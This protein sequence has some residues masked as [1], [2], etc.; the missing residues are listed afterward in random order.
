MSKVFVVIVIVV[1]IDGHFWFAGSKKNRGEVHNIDS[2]AFAAEKVHAVTAFAG[3]MSRKHGAT[4]LQPLCLSFATLRSVFRGHGR[5]WRLTSERTFETFTRQPC[6]FFCSRL[7]RHLAD[8]LSH[9]RV[10]SRVLLLRLPTATSTAAA[11]AATARERERRRDRQQDAALSLLSNVGAARSTAVPLSPSCT[12]TRRG[13]NADGFAGGSFREGGGG[14]RGISD[15]AACGGLLT[16]AFGG[17]KGGG[18]L[19]GIRLLVSVRKN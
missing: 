16:T 6:V 2:A 8:T 18:I 4:P 3:V 13:D 14:D 9:L 1:V 12:G 19:E 5:D 11:A 10:S 7:A 15:A 17:A